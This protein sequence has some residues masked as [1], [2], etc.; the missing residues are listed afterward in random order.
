MLGYELSEVAPDISSWEKIVDPAAAGD[1][2]HQLDEQSGRSHQ[3]LPQRT[4]L[5][6]QGRFMDVGFGYWTGSRTRFRGKP[7]RALG[8]HIDIT[9]TKEMERRLRESDQQFLAIF[10]QTA[11]LLWV[12]SPEGLIKN[13]NQAAIDFA[14]VSWSS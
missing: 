3:Y 1:V 9:S 2:M 4:S 10:D 11:H 5:A 7:L 8:V 6:P 13:A 12:L 14:K